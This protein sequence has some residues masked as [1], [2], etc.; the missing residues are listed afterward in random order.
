MS[1]KHLTLEEYQTLSTKYPAVVNTSNFERLQKSIGTYAAQI[2]EIFPTEQQD[3]NSWEANEY[4]LEHISIVGF[5]VGEILGL[6]VNSPDAASQLGTYYMTEVLR[7]RRDQRMWRSHDGELVYDYV[8]L[9]HGDTSIGCINPQTNRSEY[10]GFTQSIYP[11]A[12]ALAAFIHTFDPTGEN[13]LGKWDWEDTYFNKP[14]FWK[15]Q[16]KIPDPDVVEPF[17]TFGE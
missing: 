6:T 15:G 11:F 17:H 12:L 8:L 16:V 3:M 13:T 5:K 2:L 10:L 9:D 7:N 14:N 1:L 4:I